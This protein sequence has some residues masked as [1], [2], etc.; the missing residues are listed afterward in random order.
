MKIPL[1]FTAVKFGKGVYFAKQAWY[2]AKYIYS[3][4]DGEGLQYMYIARVLVGK[5]TK[6]KD[7]SCHPQLMKTTRSLP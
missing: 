7:Y 3:V 2:S 5:Y 6:R 1:F 4:P